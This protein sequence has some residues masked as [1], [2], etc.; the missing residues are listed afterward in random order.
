MD[1]NLRIVEL[2]SVEDTRDVIE[3][4][5][6]WVRLSGT[7]DARPCDRCGRAHEIHAT[8]RLE[9]GSSAVVGTGCMKASDLLQAST[10][11]SAISRARRVQ[12]LG[13]KLER[14]A[15]RLAAARAIALEVQGLELPPVVRGEHVTESGKRVATLEMGDTVLWC[16]SSARTVEELELSWRGDELRRRLAPLGVSSVYR[17]EQDER[18]ARK[19]LARLERTAS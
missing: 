6:R 5:D 12:D 4:G 17:L 9:D 15:R 14:T 2:L 1:A 10:V 18:D 19:A 16:W 7:G 13:L 3:E 8:V 11:R